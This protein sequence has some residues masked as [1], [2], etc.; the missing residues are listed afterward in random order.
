MNRKKWKFRLGLGLISISV[1]LFL[2]LFSLP[3]LPLNVKIKL[4]LSPAL[5]VAGEVMFWLGILLIGKDVY[6]RF[7]TRLMSGE[8]G[9]KKQ[10]P[11]KE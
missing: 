6:L 9:K 2:L 1:V 11:S 3:F 7:K 10:T 8:W 4:A 5:L